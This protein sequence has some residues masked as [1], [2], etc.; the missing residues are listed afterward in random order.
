MVLN[1]P[2]LLVEYNK[3]K[4]SVLPIIPKGQSDIQDGLAADYLQMIKS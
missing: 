1:K 2:K 3:N 4:N